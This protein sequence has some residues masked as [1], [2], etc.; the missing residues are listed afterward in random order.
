[1]RNENSISITGTVMK[2]ALSLDLPGNLTMDDVVFEARFYIYGNKVETIPKSGMVRQDSGTY[3]LALDTSLLGGDGRVKCQISVD[4]PDANCEDGV[5]TEIIRV[6][7]DEI[8][9]NGV[10]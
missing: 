5:R 2:F 9:R 3:I 8:V 1:M 10:R 4:I 7:T 6:E